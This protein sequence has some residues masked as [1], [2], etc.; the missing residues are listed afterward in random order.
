MN[1]APSLK[2]F[3]CTGPSS[4][5]KCWVGPELPANGPDD[6]PPNQG[7]PSNTDDD[8]DDDDEEDPP[9]ANLAQAILLMTYELI[10]PRP[11]SLTLLMALTPESLTTS[12]SSANS[13]SE[14][15]PLILKMQP[16]WPLPYPTSTVLLWSTLSQQSSIPTKSPNGWIKRFLI[17]RIDVLWKTRCVLVENEI[18]RLRDEEGR[19]NP[20]FGLRTTASKNVMEKMTQEE[21]IR[22]NMD[23]AE[24]ENNGY[25]EE[26]K[27]RMVMNCYLNFLLTFCFKRLA[28]RYHKKCV[29]NT[30][31]SQYL[32]TGM[33]S[34]VLTCYKYS[35]GKP[36]VNW[37]V[38]SHIL[39]VYLTNTIFWLV[40][41]ALL[42]WWVFHQPHLLIHLIQV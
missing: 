17:R 20:D 39:I 8:D 37:Y 34:V 29:Y 2:P 26:H 5:P 7:T 41:T 4:S 6:F 36:V 25:L 30:L 10:K 9:E 16:R 11:R 31:K 40:S 12:F 21:L 19:T 33:V 27:R 42:N 38:T 13:T 35:D 15:M 18:S 3:P 32:E 24:M 28:K 22:L 14:P 23:M 1:H